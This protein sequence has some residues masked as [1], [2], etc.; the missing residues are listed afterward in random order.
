M[1]VNRKA[2]ALPTQERYGV[3]VIQPQLIMTM[4]DQQSQILAS[5]EKL[6]KCLYKH[7]KNIGSKSFKQT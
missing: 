6:T 3:L 1:L 5:L 4:G 7:F 2:P